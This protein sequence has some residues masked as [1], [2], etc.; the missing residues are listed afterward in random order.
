MTLRSWLV[1]R[2]LKAEVDKRIR[3]MLPVRDDTLGDRNMGQRS[4]DSINQYWKA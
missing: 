2:F 1:N 4:I 3:L